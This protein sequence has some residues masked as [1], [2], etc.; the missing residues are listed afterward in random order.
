MKRTLT[1]IQIRRRRV[2][3]YQINVPLCL[4]DGE[5]APVFQKAKQIT[6]KWAR[7]VAKREGIKL[8]N[9]FDENAFSL[10][11]SNGQ[12]HGAGIPEEGAWAIRV[13]HQDRT[14]RD[15]LWVVDIALLHHE[16][17]VQFGL[18]LGRLV[19]KDRRVKLN[20]STPRVVKDI[21][22]K[23]GF[24]D[25]RAIRGKPWVIGSASEV[26]TLDK[27]LCSKGR[28]FKDLILTEVT[29]PMVD[30]VGPYLLDH[31]E[32]AKNLVGIAN[33]YCI[34]RKFFGLWK[35]QWEHFPSDGD[36]MVMSE[37]RSLIEASL[38]DVLMTR[39]HM[40]RGVKVFTN[41][42]TRDFYEVARRSPYESYPLRFL[43]AIRSEQRLYAVEKMDDKDEI[44]SLYETEVDDLNK[45]LQAAEEEVL[46]H[47]VQAE[48]L[49]LDLEVSRE[50][51]S[52]HEYEISRLRALL[53]EQMGDPDSGIPI[54]D[55]YA[56][57]GLWAK[58]HLSGRL[59]LLPRAERMVKNSNWPDIR[60]VY[61]SL[62]L[63]ATVYRDDRLTDT[64]DKDADRVDIEKAL[65]DLDSGLRLTRK[66]SAATNFSDYKVKWPKGSHK[67]RLL[68][69]HL[70][71]G[72][73][74]DSSKHMRIYFFWCSDKK[75]VVV[76]ALTKHLPNTLTN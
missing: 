13:Q 48:Q 20:D 69:S 68:E 45:R 32:L 73:S 7:G 49:A 60:L 39:G 38:S 61:R 56:E 71:K 3:V 24:W 67:T 22:Q 4:M 43:D 36:L 1:R 26:K 53:A 2:N 34:P 27:L 51:V 18:R 35:E 16:G 40:E 11:S 17:G 5:S 55:N 14:F 70:K 54:P 75:V 64:S 23:I 41:N 46:Q 62:I 12:F 74:P 8:P 44:I 6:L 19:P 57:M 76:G 65:R 66:D 9:N 59:V 50:T 47:M 52:A 28:V 15:D 33:V 29:L 21:A 25:S 58:T 37:G 10:V 30:P 31:M 72:K 63:L 42:I